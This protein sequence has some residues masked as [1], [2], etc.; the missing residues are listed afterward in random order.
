MARKKRN[1]QN[2]DERYV[3]GET[4]QIELKYIDPIERKR[5][6][7]LN[8]N[9]LRFTFAHVI[10]FFF[11]GRCDDVIERFKQLPPGR[12]DGYVANTK[13][14]MNSDALFKILRDETHITYWQ[15]EE[16]AKLSRVPSGAI[17]LLS[18]MY[19]LVRDQKEPAAEYFISALREFV[20]QLEKMQK[21]G[22]IGKAEMRAF[23][24][25]FAKFAES[26]DMPLLNE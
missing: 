12:Y 22:T 1:R 26:E 8:P 24:K 19:A 4:E 25:C 6:G 15:L 20:D 13:K 9:S 21:N 17:L 23:Q 18:R 10:E 11:D 7:K 16:F 14:T 3:I 2:P 5:S